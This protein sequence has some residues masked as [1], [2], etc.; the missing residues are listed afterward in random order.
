MPF[1][2]RGGALGTLAELQA[3]LQMRDD[4]GADSRHHGGEHASPTDPAPRTTC[5]LGAQKASG[6]VEKRG[7]RF[8]GDAAALAEGTLNDHH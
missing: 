1:K 3:R 4:K 8:S 5:R 7:G 6:G 2:T